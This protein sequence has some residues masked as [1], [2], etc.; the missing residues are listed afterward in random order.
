MAP[1]RTTSKMRTGQR[2]G[3]LVAVS[4]SGKDKRNNVRWLYRCDCGNEHV[5]SASSVRNGYTTSCGCY[6]KE[7]AAINGRTYDGSHHVTHGLRHSPEYRVWANMIARCERPSTDRYQE[8]GGRGIKVCE[9]WRNSFETF[10]AYLGAKPSP[11]HS[12]ERIDVNGNYAPG[13]VR[14]ATRAEQMRN[15]RSNV[16]VVY[17]GQKMIFKDACKLAG[18]NYLRARKLYL[19]GLPIEHVLAPR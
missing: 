15:R 11:S 1:G 12:I 6:Q 9:E 8:Y 2:Y 5:T 19:D 3:R 14:W 7:L 13:N 17:R 4:Y 18:V 16:F 10:F